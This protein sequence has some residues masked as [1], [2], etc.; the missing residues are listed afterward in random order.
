MNLD[1]SKLLFLEIRKTVKRTL[2]SLAS[3]C[4]FGL[5][6]VGIIIIISD[7]PSSVEIAFKLL[8]KLNIS[9]Y[10]ESLKPQRLGLSRGL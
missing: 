10:F 5:S 2:K 9:L 8:Y 7:L 6:T 4:T 3:M 1:Q